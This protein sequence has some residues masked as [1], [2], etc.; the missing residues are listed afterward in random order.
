MANIKR[1]VDQIMLE[2]WCIFQLDD[3]IFF[4][5]ATVIIQKNLWNKRIAIPFTILLQYNNMLPI[6]LSHE[7]YSIT[8][9]FI[10]IGTFLQTALKE[11]L[12]LWR[13]NVAIG[14]QTVIMT[15]NFLNNAIVETTFHP[16]RRQN[17]Q[18]SCG[19]FRIKFQFRASINVAFLNYQTADFMNT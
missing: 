17:K 1:K 15:L 2:N 14:F 9:F 16:K 3:K 18:I 7:I 5:K 10:S 6:I 11:N 19:N 4:L 12:K 13:N 8:F